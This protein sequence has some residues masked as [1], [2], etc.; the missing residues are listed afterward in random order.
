MTEVNGDRLEILIDQ[1]GRLTEAI[2]R[3]RLEHNEAI[4]RSRLEHNEAIERSRLEHNER[5][6]SLDLRLDRVAASTERQE[7]NIARLAAT[8]ERQAQIVETL[9]ARL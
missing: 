6:S 8:V 1:I 4:E 5:Y 2:E 9:I 3:S 7:L